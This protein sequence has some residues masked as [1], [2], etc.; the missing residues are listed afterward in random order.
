VPLAEACNRVETDPSGR[1]V[2][3]VTDPEI[4]KMITDGV[5]PA[6]YRRIKAPVLGI[7]NKVTP[8]TRLPYYP[9]LDPATQAEFRRSMR[10]LSPWTDDSIRRFRDE[11]KH[12]RVIELPYTNHYVFIVQEWL[13]VREAREFLLEK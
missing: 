8:E 1:V 5:T 11:V 2:G 6:Q 12:G 9:Y 3:S 13:V 7:F 4:D 10:A